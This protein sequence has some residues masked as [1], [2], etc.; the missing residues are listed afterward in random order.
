MHRRFVSIT[1]AWSCRFS[2]CV[3]SFNPFASERNNTIALRHA[4]SAGSTRIDLKRQSVSCSVRMSCAIYE[5]IF[6]SFNEILIFR[7]LKCF[8]TLSCLFSGEALLFEQ[9][10]ET[11]KRE[12]LEGSSGKHHWIAFSRNNADHDSSSKITW[13]RKA[14]LAKLGRFFAHLTAINSNRALVS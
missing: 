9:C 7:I 2:I 6:T 3:A 11:E 10:S 14:K 5:N 1:C 8:H 12:Q 4:N 13:S